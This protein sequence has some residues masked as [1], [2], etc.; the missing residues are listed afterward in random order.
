MGLGV[1]ILVYRAFR[2]SEG[3]VSNLGFE[4]LLGGGHEGRMEG[5][6]DIEQDCA[7]RTGLFEQLYG[8]FDGFDLARDDELGGGIVVS[9]D[10]YAVDLLTD[11]FD[12]M[13]V[14]SDD[15]SHRSG[16]EFAGLLHCQ[17]AL[18]YEEEPVF[19]VDGVGCDQSRPL[20]ERVPRHCIEMR[21]LL[22]S[23]QTGQ[24]ME[25]N[26]KISAAASKS[27]CT[28]G[29]SGTSLPIPAYCAP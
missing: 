25:E 22:K 17:G 2:G 1:D 9:R 4:V 29:V 16:K 27:L 11:S 6:A 21:W 26:S 3:G 13:E 23:V 18:A 5:S 24:R 8:F 10:D 19:E 20:T 7:S 14:Q 12:A 15:G 28:R